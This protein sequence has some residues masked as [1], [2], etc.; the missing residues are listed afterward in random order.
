MRWVKKLCLVVGD[1]LLVVDAAVQ[2]DV[3][4]EGQESHAA[5]LGHRN[6]QLASYRCV[7]SRPVKAACIRA[8][9]RTGW[10]SRGQMKSSSPTDGAA[11]PCPARFRGSFTSAASRRIF[12]DRRGGATVP[13][14]RGV[15]RAEDLVQPS[16]TRVVRLPPLWEQR[17]ACDVSNARR[18]AK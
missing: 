12:V 6:L 7:I 5:S 4:A 3:D 17:R 16:H 1:S 14:M 18:C 2:V 9:S 11:A 15:G 8:R 10:G 13:L